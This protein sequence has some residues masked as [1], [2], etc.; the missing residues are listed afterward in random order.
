MAAGRGTPPA[1][2]DIF[3]RAHT[4]GPKKRP[5]RQRKD[6]RWPNAVLVFDTETTLDTE[7]ALTIGAYRRCRLVDGT[8]VCAEEGVFHADTIDGRQRAVLDAYM[9]EETADIGITSFPPR[10]KLSRHSRAE[11]VKRVFWTAVQRGEMVVGFNLPFDLSRLAVQWPTGHH[12]SWSLVLSLRRSRKT[13]RLE[14][15]PYRPRVRV[16]ATDSQSAFITATLPYLP[17]EW[18]EGRFLDLHTLAKALYDESSR[19]IACMSDCLA[20]QAK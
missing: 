15:N 16:T 7:Q 3:L 20:S 1:P 8:Y 13:K 10:L 18:A 11:F 6:P 19:W 17:G 4:V 2:Q 14:A 9:R 5:P 12:G